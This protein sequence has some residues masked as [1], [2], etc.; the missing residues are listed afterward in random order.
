MCVC[1]WR[2]V[3]VCVTVVCAILIMVMYND[4]IREYYI[5]MPAILHY[6]AA[7]ERLPEYEP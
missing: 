1:V 4:K 7:A 2:S 5:I 3:Y 6:L